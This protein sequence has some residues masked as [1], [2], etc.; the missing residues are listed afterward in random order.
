MIKILL[1]ILSLSAPLV[2]QTQISPKVIQSFPPHIIF[3]IDKV[4]SKVKLTEDQQMKF[5][6][7][8]SKK[9]SLANIALGKEK[10]TN[11]LKR[12]YNTNLNFLKSILSQE[13]LDLYML[14]YDKKNR[15]LLALKSAKELQL[16]AKQIEQIR[17]QNNIAAKIPKKIP[18][19]KWHFMLKN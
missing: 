6:Q 17:I 8:L 19:K 10:I 11:N 7:E 13:Q 12:A 9:D 5:G 4:T 1:I 14:Q 18:P 16:D 2:A 3:K 15:F